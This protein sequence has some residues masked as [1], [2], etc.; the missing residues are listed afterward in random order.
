M[1][2]PLAAI[3]RR[4]GFDVIRFSNCSHVK[5]GESAFTKCRARASDF[6]SV[7]AAMPGTPMRRTSVISAVMV[8]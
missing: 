8:A 3:Y 7:V 5:N 2:Q 6:P 4:K 1:H